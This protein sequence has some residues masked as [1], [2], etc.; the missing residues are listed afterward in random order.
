MVL[1][2]QTLARRP[3]P[4]DLGV[5]LVMH[6]NRTTIEGETALRALVGLVKQWR[7][8]SCVHKD[9]GSGD[10]LRLVGMQNRNVVEGSVERSSTLARHQGDIRLRTTL[11]A[12]FKPR[13]RDTDQD[14]YW[15]SP[16]THASECCGVVLDVDTAEQNL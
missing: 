11:Q 9:A 1:G 6:M 15:D 12:E 10:D 13:K 5:V 4:T 8:R 3:E 2:H 16:E 7:T 14:Q